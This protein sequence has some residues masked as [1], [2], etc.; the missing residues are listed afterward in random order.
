MEIFLIT[1][2]QVRTLAFSLFRI[3]SFVCD[4][5]YIV[6][7]IIII[8][9]FVTSYYLRVECLQL[10]TRNR[11]FLHGALQNNAAVLWLLF[12]LHV[13]ITCIT[14]VFKFHMRCIST[15]KSLYLKIF[16]DSLLI[17]FL[18]AEI[19]MSINRHVPFSL[20]LIKICRLLLGRFGKLPLLK[21]IIWLPYFHDLFVLIL[22][23][24][25]T[26]VSCLILYIFPCVCLSVV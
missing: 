17:I 11:P 5:I 13:L 8:I 15:V 16:S 10:Y 22:I 9:I 26:A 19:V 4:Y 6:F 2:Y 1:K 18:Y 21:S 3:M 7:T 24:T 12:L 14:F 23:N 20:S 25:H